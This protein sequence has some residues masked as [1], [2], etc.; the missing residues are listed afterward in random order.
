MATCLYL[1]IVKADH[2]LYES[3]EL[4]TDSIPINREKKI[5][6]EEL[7]QSLGIST[8]RAKELVKEVLSKRG[9]KK[10]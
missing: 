6:L 8:E 2:I 3:L 9:K 7:R 5:E 10:E 1:R 4:A